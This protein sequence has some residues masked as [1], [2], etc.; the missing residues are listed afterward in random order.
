MKPSKITP[1]RAW[2]FGSLVFVLMLHSQA[3]AQ[4]A[5]CQDAADLRAKEIIGKTRASILA[6]GEKLAFSFLDRDSFAVGPKGCIITFF[7]ED[8]KVIGSEV[9]QSCCEKE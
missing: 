2:G 1:T 4:R 5:G 9:S 6:K 8:E 3:F 7:Y